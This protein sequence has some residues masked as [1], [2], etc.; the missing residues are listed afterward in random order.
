V[1]RESRARELSRR[2]VRADRVLIG[3][4]EIIAGWLSAAR[5]SAANLPSVLGRIAHCLRRGG[6]NMTLSRPD[7][8]IAQRLMQPSRAVLFQRFFL[9]WRRTTIATSFKLG[10]YTKTR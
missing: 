8:V 6:A 9:Q 4:V 10:S 3:E 7:F 1:A 2:R 5:R